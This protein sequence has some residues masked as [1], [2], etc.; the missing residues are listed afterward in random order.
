[1]AQT[2]NNKGWQIRPDLELIKRLERLALKFKRETANKL[3]VEIL[4]DCADIWEDAE[5]AR[6]DVLL[7]HRQRGQAIKNKMLRPMHAV[8]ADLNNKDEVKKGRK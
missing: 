1:M 2:T 5:Q 7:Q 6:Q 4:R 3:A 8:G